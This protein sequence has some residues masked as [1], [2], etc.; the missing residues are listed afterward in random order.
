MAPCPDQVS[1]QPHSNQL[2]T[3]GT[4]ASGIAHEINT[5]I[6][7]IGDNLQFINDSFGAVDRLL[8]CYASLHEAA[9]AAG[10]LDRETAMLSAAL[11]EAELDF[12]RDEL[13][14]A[15]EQSLAG[16]Q[17]VARIASAMKSF[18][19]R[20]S[21]EKEMADINQ[22]IDMTATICRNEW[23]YDADLELDLD[24]G[25]PRMSCHIGALSQVWLNL[26]VNAAHAIKARPDRERG[27]ITIKTSSD[28]GWIR[29]T[30]A[31]NGT[32]IPDQLR[33][34]VFEPFFSTKDA[35]EGSG[36]GLSICRKIVGEQHGGGIELS[37][38]V[39]R[40]STFTVSLPLEA[41]T[42]ASA[43]CEEVLA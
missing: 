19:R 3:L 34:R 5:P 32:G 27:L 22:A 38:E 2:A 41:E 18:A 8:G 17:Q 31:D 43:S 42:T 16:I 33:E 11:E 30:V 10:L 28:N 40:G 13:S 15:I 37:T 9:L 25:L 1:T 23:K 4:M 26:I 12:L 36:Q 20:G 14:G 29:V 35:G 21:A 39:G 7:F 24:P 6:Q